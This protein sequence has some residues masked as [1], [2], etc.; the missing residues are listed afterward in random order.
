M[1]DSKIWIWD[2]RVRDQSVSC[3]A[4]F[5]CNPKTP[6]PPPPA[7]PSNTTATPTPAP[8]SSSSL[9]LLYVL[10]LMLGCNFRKMFTINPP[11]PAS[12]NDMCLN[13]ISPTSGLCVCERERECVCVCVCVCLCVQR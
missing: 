3:G 5:S 2:P 7:L 11:T 12:P 6:H 1:F 4:V 13:D 9:P 10:F 8:V